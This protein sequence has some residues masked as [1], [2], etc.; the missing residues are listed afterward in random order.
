MNKPDPS[1]P[2]DASFPMP[3]K[4]PTQVGAGVLCGVVAGL[5]GGAIVGPL[6][7]LLGLGL[8]IGIG[9]AA[10]LVI[11]RE[12]EKH[13]ERTRELDAIIG[14]TEGS[15]GAGPVSL[16]PPAPESDAPESTETERETWLAEWLTPP[17]P[18]AQT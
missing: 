13:G 9:A 5:A 4:L 3:R 6:G 14:I 12:D 2:Q 16:V 15:L 18:A 11:D 8:G 7:L 10:G 1:D 17:P